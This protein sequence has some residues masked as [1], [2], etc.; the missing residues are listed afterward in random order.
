MNQPLKLVH[1]VQMQSQVIALGFG[2]SVRNFLLKFP[3]YS[4]DIQLRSE[5]SSFSVFKQLTI[6]VHEKGMNA[7]LPLAILCEMEA[8]EEEKFLLLRNLKHH[9][10]LRYIPVI[11]ISSCGTNK[12]GLALKWGFDDYFDAPVRWPD[13]YH[14]LQF[15]NKFKRELVNLAVKPKV[16]KPLRI[17]FWKRIIDFT[18]SLFAILLISPILLIISLAIKFES[19]GP[20][21][22]K[23][24]RVG[25]G[26]HVF[27]FYKFRS[28]YKDADKRLKDLQHLNQYGK[29]NNLFMKIGNDPRVTP[30]GRFL[31]KTSLDELP[32]LFNILKGDMSLV[33]NRPLPLYEAEMLTRDAWAERFLA[34]AGLTGLWQ[35]TKRGKSDMS[36]EERIQLD[37]E[38][39]RRH[40][41]WFD[42]RI[43]WKTVPAMLQEENV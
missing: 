12:K 43:I 39:A 37:I 21:F 3:H 33:G 13:L 20:V 24:K 34:P 8:M 23:S 15:L 26:Y 2:P 5:T 17:A 1:Q 38:Y 6:E 4:T 25:T 16:V 42:L 40:S 30:F 35:V 18:V 32:Q 10:V 14:R 9:P 31:R 41:V 22:Y 28:M 7:E 29:S 27:D 36:S 19:R 11:A